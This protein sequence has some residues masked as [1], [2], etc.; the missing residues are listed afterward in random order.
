MQVG[1]GGHP[2]RALPHP[3]CPLSCHSHVC[4]LPRACPPA[5]AHVLTA[6]HRLARPADSFAPKRKKG[7]DEDDGG[8]GVVHDDVWCLD[9]KA[10]TFERVKKQGAGDSAP[11]RLGALPTAAAV[12]A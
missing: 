3:R 9:L 4:I 7:D 11:G 1:S 8:K 2:G 6:L 10:L 12:Q 5:R